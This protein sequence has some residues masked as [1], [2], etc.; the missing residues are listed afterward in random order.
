M[1]FKKNLTMSSSWYGLENDESRHSAAL[2][3]SFAMVHLIAIYLAYTSIRTVYNVYFHPLS[4]IPGPKLWI[5]FPG[6]KWIS[7]IRGTI[8]ADVR[9]WHDIYGSTVR[10]SPDELSFTSAQAWKDIYSSKN[11]PEMPKRQVG[12]AGRPANILSCNTEDH[13]RFRKALGEGFSER[14]LRAQEGVIRGYIDL[15]VSRLKEQSKYD[16]SIDLVHWYNLV[17]FDIIGDLS[18]GRSFDCLRNARLHSFIK[19]IVDSMPMLPIFAGAKEYPVLMFLLKHCMPKRV[20]ESRDRQ[21]AFAQECIEQRTSQTS[22]N[23]RNDFMDSLMKT[24]GTANEVSKGEMVSNAYIL[25]IAGS[26]TTATALAAATYGLL[27]TP[28]AL[29][30]ATKEVRSKFQSEDDIS[31][32]TASVQQLPYTH[33]CLQEALRLHP[34]VP[35]PTSRVTVQSCSTIAGYTVPKGTTVGLHQSSAYVDDRNFQ[36]AK[37]FVPERW[38]DENKANGGKYCHDSK[39]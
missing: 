11:K 34:P 9:H 8:D 20:K 27:V 39:I 31:F 4:R 16:E 3:V 23:D 25:L 12:E 18:F 5:A 26:E 36:N 15:F 10:L 38:L 6:L 13:I 21:F 7:A 19:R 29:D 30:R 24:H 17:T 32:S 14:A 28:R 2:I 33:A 22:D 37:E 1:I 35:G